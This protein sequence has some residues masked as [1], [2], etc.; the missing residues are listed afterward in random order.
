MLPMKSAASSTGCGPITPP[1][2]N[3]LRYRTSPPRCRHP[4]TATDLTPQFSRA[5]PHDIQEILET[6]VA[7]GRAQQHG[8]NS[9]FRGRPLMKVSPST[10]QGLP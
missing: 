1:W 10:L 9:G 6:L 7:L 2:P 5:K 3:H 8:E 4:V